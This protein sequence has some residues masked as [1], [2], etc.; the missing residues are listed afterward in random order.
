MIT[1]STSSGP[2]TGP[3]CRRREKNRLFSN[4]DATTG[5]AA[6]RTGVVSLSFSYSKNQGEAPASNPNG[7]SGGDV[8]EEEKWWGVAAIPAPSRCAERPSFPDSARFAK[9]V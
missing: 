1:S 8:P 5:N 9:E 2:L 4:P 7:F 3:Q 6:R